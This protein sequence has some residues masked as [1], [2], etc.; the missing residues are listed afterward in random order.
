MTRQRPTN[1]RWLSTA[2]LLAL[3]CATPALAQAPASTPAPRGETAPDAGASFPAEFFAQYNPVTAADMVARVPGFELR[4]GDDRRG[5]AATAGNLLVNG[6]RPSSKAAPSDL[7]KRIPAASVLRI[8]LL[9]GSNSTIDIRGQSQ[10]VNV[11]VNRATRA[12]SATTF[13]AGLRHIQYSNRIGWALQASRTL[14]LTPT[15]ELALDIQAP[16]TLGRG[17]V[18]ERLASGAGVFTGTRYQV[19]KANNRTL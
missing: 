10:V 14:S 5:F 16:N 8:E 9:S 13:V 2:S 3:A 4:D 18:R 17:V 11:V 7:L 19:S 12:D 1:L 6:E 15:A